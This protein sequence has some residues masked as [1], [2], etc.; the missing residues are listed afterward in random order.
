MNIEKNADAAR[1]SYWTSQMESAFG[2]MS[3]IR[4]Y[5]VEECGEPLVSLPDAAAAE[6]V[7]VVFSDT[8]IAGLHPRLFYLREGLIQDFIA[9]AKEMNKRGWTLKVEDG[10]R[11]RDMQKDIALQEKVL[12]VILRKVVWEIGGAAPDPDPVLVFRRLTALSATRP[13][14]GTH[15][16]GSAIDIT[17]LRSDDLSEIDRGGPYIELSELTPMD[18]PFVSPEAARNRAEISGIM[19]RRGFIAYP[20][21]FWHYSKGDAYAERLTNSGKPARY[22]AVDVDLP[23]GAVAPIPNPDESLH[24]VEDFK[25][26]IESA[27]DRLKG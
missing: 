14:I 3:E 2:F 27:L 8:L 9:A 11:S 20:Y 22:G 4:K 19:S 5:P 24:S 7:S 16:S 23:S 25:R 17:V 6:G 13:K 1:R 26:H 21:E 10:F 12:G 18:S 15:M